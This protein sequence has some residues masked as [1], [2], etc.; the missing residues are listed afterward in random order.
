M[1]WLAYLVTALF[2]LSL[3]VTLSLQIFNNTLLNSKFIEQ[4]ADQTNTYSKISEGLN[5]E[6]VKES[7]QINNPLVTAQLQQLI[8]P[9]L[10]RQK[11][12]SALDQLMAYY[13]NQ[14]PPPEINLTA[15][16]QQLT[17]LGVPVPPN[18][19]LNKPIELSGSSKLKQLASSYETY[20]LASLIATI[21]LFVI[22]VVLSVIRHKY[23]VLAVAPIIA[24]ILLVPTGLTLLLFSPIANH[25]IKL[26]S[27]SN[28]FISASDSLVSAISKSIGKDFL[29][30]SV[31][32]IVMGILAIIILSVLNKN[33]TKPRV[34]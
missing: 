18:S 34:A 24:G 1:K 4:K 26:H 28:A 14:G 3:C 19:Q 15:Q 7:G 21:A 22:L 6:L 23:K 16:A 27:T 25:F 13:K 29:F 11:V 17:A 30:A 10:I 8:T 31:V 20:K 33:Q 5:N 9:A 12:N 32:L 2:V